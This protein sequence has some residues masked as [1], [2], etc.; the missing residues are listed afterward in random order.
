MKK[1]K[2]KNRKHSLAKNNF[3]VFISFFIIFIITLSLSFLVLIPNSVKAEVDVEN[4]SYPR[5]ANY[6]LHWEL[7]DYEAKELAKWDLLI[8]DMEVSQNSPDKIRKIRELN[9]DIIILAYI[10]SQEVMDD[11]IYDHLGFLRYD[12]KNEIVDSW[13][14]KSSDGNKLSYWQNTY[15]LNLS[16]LSG[17]NSSGLKFNEF[18]PQFINNEILSTALFDGVFYDNAWGDV[19]WSSG[20]DVDI[21]ND[22]IKDEVSYINSQWEEGY[23]KM[24]EVSKDLFGNDYIIIGNGKIHLPYQDKLNGMM[25]E[26][27]PASWEGTWSDSLNTYS[28]LK[29][30]N[31]EPQ[32]S[33]INSYSK[34][35]EN[36]SKM[37]FGLTST[38]LENGFYSFDYDTSDHGQLWWYDEYDFNLG[39]ETGKA[40]DVLN[41]NNNNY[42]YYPSLWRRNF[43]NGSVFVNSSNLKQTLIFKGEKF[44]K[45]KGDQDTKVNNGNEINYISLEP[46]SG[47]ILKGNDFKLKNAIFK[48][49]YYYKY[50]DGR[51][52]EKRKAGFAFN[53]SYPGQAE[54]AFISQNKHPEALLSTYKGR[55]ELREG[56]EKLLDFRP[57]GAFSGDLSIAYSLNNNNLEKIAVGAGLGGGPQVMLYDKSGRL[58]RNFFA[59]DK[60]L[61]GGVNVA[62]FDVDNDSYQEIITGP[63]PGEEPV[64]KV[65]DEMGNMINSFLAYE[66]NFTGGVNVVAGDLNNDGNVEIITVPASGGGPQLRI[67]DYE[68][69]IL[70]TFFAFDKDINGE[71]VVSLSDVDEDGNADIVV[72]QKN[73][74]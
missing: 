48:N 51:G 14:L 38:L 44:F 21:N 45:L 50:L 35:K 34:N 73:P 53:S 62:I 25:L 1:T 30:F 32:V 74:Y 66:K 11:L 28:N 61:R 13:Y 52:E 36:Y 42:K 63:G 7:S 57:F 19:T 67:F 72:G 69:N 18:L 55:V 22:G 10:T 46:N 8:L 60:N 54:L 64:I 37:R 71:F 65:F 24:L 15:L 9:P 2:D 68:G 29:K 43:E 47:I 27:F 26:G 31:K 59:Y 3:S 12:L 4:I 5:L 39:N 20:D 58:E 40:I 16:N 23:N 70:G 17:S 49:G 6:F 56:N 41:N 33:I